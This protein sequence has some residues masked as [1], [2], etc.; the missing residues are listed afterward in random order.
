MKTSFR[1][2]AL[3]AMFAVLALTSV[4]S[5]QTPLGTVFTYQGRLT[6]AGQ[7]VNNTADFQFTLWDAE[8]AGN[9]VGAMSPVGNVTVANGLFTVE[10]N[11][12]NEFGGDAFNGEAR[13]L[14]IAVRSPSGQGQFTPVVPR[15]ELS[16]TPYA[17][18]AMNADK[19]DGLDSSA[20]LQS[21]PIPLTLNG[22]SAT[23]IIR[24]QNTS[25]AGG[26]SGVSG[27]ATATSGDTSGVFG[28]SS[29]NSGRGVSGTANSGFG[30]TY[31]VY[32]TSLSPDGRG[33]YGTG[34]TGVYGQSFSGT[35]WGVYGLNSGPSGTGVI[36]LA[37]ALSGTSSG[38]WGNSD[39]TS[40]RGVYGSGAY[41]VY[42]RGAQY[43][44]YGQTSGEEAT[45]VHGQ[46]DGV[47]GTGVYGRVT[48]M[49]FEESYGGR[50]VADGP[51]GNAVW[52]EANSTSGV[53]IGVVGV[54]LGS[55][56]Y[57]M[58]SGGDVR[59][60]GDLTV[61]GTKIGYVSDIV[62]NGGEEPL[63]TG[64]LV[65][66]TGNADP[67]LGN[68]PVIVVRKAQ[69][70]NSTSVLGPMDCALDVQPIEEQEVELRSKLPAR[71]QYEHPQY[72]VHKTYGAILP[73]GYGR[74]VTL[75]S[76]KAIKV[77]ASFGAVQPGDLLVSSPNPGYAMRSDSPAIGTVVGKA[78]GAWKHGLGAV[79]V[80]VQ[81]R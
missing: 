33:V 50:F 20:F 10:I 22:G 59:I 14:E 43:G 78:L 68:I 51:N 36:G 67:I 63:E 4:V 5:A 61:T 16:A 55:V 46:S 17:L 72:H 53:G 11:A 27:L 18:F 54:S 48:D 41:G 44:V 70:A 66:I 24:G 62:R 74:A 65:E 42:G 8:A 23:H 56:G 25:S 58:V 38:V 15:E 12:N 34:N 79:P 81:S 29:S 73:N 21:V 77:D 76:F 40:G 69:A 39:S 1:I 32:G 47:S 6:L 30:T 64:D 57:G 2:A 37:T 28:Q 3:A 60:V 13:W 9:Q 75:G 19:L 26:A 35:G 52:G 7:P 80:L 49:G 45:G 71:L 31:G